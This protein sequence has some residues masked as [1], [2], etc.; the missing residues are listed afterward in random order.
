M[1]KNNN[2]T[3]EK[4]RESKGLRGRASYKETERERELQGDQEGE[5]VT[6]R[7]R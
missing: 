1:W 5:R 6:R 3:K 7:Q 4:N 2:D